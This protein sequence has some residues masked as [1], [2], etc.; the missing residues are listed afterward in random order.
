MER[1][2][3]KELSNKI[4]QAKEAVSNG[5]IR[6]V[7]PIVIAADAIELD[8]QVNDLQNVLLSILDEIGP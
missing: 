6:N 1:P 2:T 7:E 8:Y 5:K 3:W 4:N